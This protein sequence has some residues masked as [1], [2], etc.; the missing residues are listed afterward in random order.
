MRTGELSGLGFGAGDGLATA[1]GFQSMSPV[2]GRVHLLCLLV[3]AGEA[4]QVLSQVV[5]GGAGGRS[6]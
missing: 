1:P 6:Q 4:P 5:L 3:R 2:P